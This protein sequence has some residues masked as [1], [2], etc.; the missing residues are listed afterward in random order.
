MCMNFSVIVIMC[1]Y[2]AFSS[3]AAFLQYIMSLVGKA[4]SFCVTKKRANNESKGSR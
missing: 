3:H 4:S 2:G 1:I